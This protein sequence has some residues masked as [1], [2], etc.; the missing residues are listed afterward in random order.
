[1]TTGIEDFIEGAREGLAQQTR[2]HADTWRLGEEAEWGADLESGELT[3]T[4]DDGAV[5]LAKAQVVGTYDTNDGTF[6]WGWDHPSVPE[7]LRA[8]AHLAREWGES[9]GARVFV[10]RKV[11][12]SEDEAWS[13]AAVTNRVAGA[14]GVYRGPSG[15]V[16]VFFTFG[17]VELEPAT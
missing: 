2:A 13:F 8:H 7:P 1:M 10:E 5:A 16:L 14:N 12:C 6:L 4:F 9:V 11:P 17:E 3:W 15:A